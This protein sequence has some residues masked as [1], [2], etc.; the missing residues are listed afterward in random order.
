MI[1]GFKDEFIVTVGNVGSVRIE[2]G[3]QGKYSKGHN[4]FQHFFQ[5]SSLSSDSLSLIVVDIQ[6]SKSGK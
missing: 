4:Y 1:K 5:L 2:I 6:M 3:K